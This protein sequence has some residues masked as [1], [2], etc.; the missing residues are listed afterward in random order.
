[1]RVCVSVMRKIHPASQSKA[2]ETCLHL[3]LLEGRPCQ[4]FQIIT[5]AK[6][7]REGFVSLWEEEERKK[8]QVVK[9]D[10]V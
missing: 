9:G 8:K 5:S 4:G 3:D 1:M 7:D 6:G 2:S 10:F